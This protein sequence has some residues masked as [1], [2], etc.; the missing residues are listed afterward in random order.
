MGKEA[1]KHG[2]RTQ[3]V[4]LRLWLLFSCSPA[5][6]MVIVML[7]SGMLSQHSSIHIWLH[8]QL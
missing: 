6:A 3:L 2:R 8:F 4:A 5:R 7:R 1:Q